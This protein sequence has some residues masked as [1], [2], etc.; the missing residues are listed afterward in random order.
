[1]RVRTALAV[2]LQGLVVVRASKIP[3]FS[4]NGPV[5]T[6]TLKNPESESPSSEDPRPW[7]IDW[8]S[9]RPNIL[10]EV[11]SLQPPLPYWVPVLKQLRG[12][13]GY[14]YTDLKRLPSWLE[15]TAKFASN[16]GECIVQPSYE[17]RSKRTTILLEASRGTTWILA[18]LGLAKDQVLPTLE[19]VR[20]SFVV[21]LPSPTVSSVR[22]TP[23]VDVVGKDLACQIEAVTGG[24]GRT[25]AI[26]NLEYQN[27]TLSVIHA[28]SNRHT[29]APTINLYNAKIVYQWNVLLGRTGSSSVRTKVDP[30]S[31]VE[32]TWTDQS[33]GPGSWVTDIRLPLEGTSLQALAAD[34]RVRRQFRF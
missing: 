20:S 11:S 6:L 23:S 29:I 9:L 27:P 15:G 5:V 28:L 7:P 34:I 22:I 25:R 31:A 18:K 26:L 21:H 3:R 8:A 12:R 10:W 24:F 2:V 14:Q 17:L 1:M 4:V 32:V 30:T 16:L 19:T 33:E 13:I